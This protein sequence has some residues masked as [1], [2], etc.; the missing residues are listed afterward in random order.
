MYKMNPVKKILGDRY[1]KNLIDNDIIN[2][3]KC[4]TEEAMIYIN[5]SKPYY[6][7]QI[8]GNKKFTRK[9]KT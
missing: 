9:N 7:C 4:G 2:C 8:C 6:F 1:S 5:G 3:K